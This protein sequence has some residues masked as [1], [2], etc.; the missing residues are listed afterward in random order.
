[1]QACGFCRKEPN[2]IVLGSL[3]ACKHQLHQLP[4]HWRPIQQ[5]CSATVMPLLSAR[6]S[7]STSA[8][9]QTAS[10][11]FT[12]ARGTVVRGIT[13]A[14]A[15][16]TELMS[17]PRCTSACMLADGSCCAGYEDGCVRLLTPAHPPAIAWT[18]RPHTDEV[19]GCG[20]LEGG[21]LVVAYRCARV[22]SAD[23]CSTSEHACSHV[24]YCQ[25]H[26]ERLMLPAVKRQPCL[27]GASRA[28]TSSGQ[29]PSQR[30]GMYLGLEQQ[31][32]P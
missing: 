9:T 14:C 28:R 29:R 6:D 19:T 30:R 3:C 8:P 26:E 7:Q 16:V 27:H 20:A 15:Q 17:G 32:L 10:R 1:M 21:M 12:S 23:A 2:C 13:R 4:C 24:L 25:V 11:P 18:R 5:R 22:V 31:N